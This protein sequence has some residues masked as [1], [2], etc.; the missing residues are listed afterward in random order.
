M[1]DN[2]ASQGQGADNPI[3]HTNAAPANDSAQLKAAQDKI[4]QLRDQVDQ[5]KE[6]AEEQEQ[7]KAVITRLKG[8]NGQLRAYIVHL[9]E[10]TT[11][12]EEYGAQWKEYAGRLRFMGDVY[13]NRCLVLIAILQRSFQE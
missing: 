2:T 1:S 5:L 10:Y 11:E 4:A 3:A 13:L 7:R 12:L 6:D 8:E 9:K